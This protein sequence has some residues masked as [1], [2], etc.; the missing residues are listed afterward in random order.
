MAT[1]T[2]I[3]NAV[4]TGL[5]PTIQALHKKATAVEITQATPANIWNLPH[6]KGY[7]PIIEVYDTGGVKVNADITHIDIN[8]AQV[9]IIP[10]TAGFAICK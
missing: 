9:N 7:K 6:N 2:E 5:D 3:G 8:N 1:A 10:A 4:I